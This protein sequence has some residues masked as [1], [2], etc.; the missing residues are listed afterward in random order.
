MTVR[1]ALSGAVIA[2]LLA[3]VVPMASAQTPVAHDR[4]H[5]RWAGAISRLHRDT[6]Y[7]A[8]GGTVVDALHYGLKLRWA[9]ATKTL[10][11]HETLTFRAA[12]SATRFSVELLN[13]LAV[14][15]A[16][17]NGTS[18]IPK[19]S[20]DHVT[21]AVP[22]QRGSRYVLRLTY[23]GVP[24]PVA[25]PTHRSDFSTL[26]FTPMPDGSAWTM[27]EPFGAY[28]WYAVNDTPAD[29]AYYDF[30]VT[31]P[32]GMVGVANGALKS[33]THVGS[34]TITRWHLGAPCASYLTTLAIGDYVH[35][36]LRGVKGLPIDLWT[37][38]GNRKEL[39]ILGYAPKAVHFLQHQVGRYPFSTLGIVAVPMA[40]AMET[41]T[42]VTM[43]NRGGVLNRDNV[44]HE[45]A[46]QWYGDTVTPR[47]WSDLWMNE[48]M[49]L[50]LAEI[51]WWA[52]SHHTSTSSLLANFDN[53][54]P[55]VRREF[56]APAAYDARDFGEINVYA[57]PA[58]MWDMLRQRV[59]TARFDT[60]IRE[61]PAT[62]RHAS[63]SRGG[64]IRWW[65]R[66]TD[67]DLTH[68]FRRW[69]LATKEPHWH[70]G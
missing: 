39:R 16:R 25:A 46:H 40:S 36:V 7:P 29:K 62:H 59:G 19:H 31:A 53:I 65:S 34:S 8:H 44:V 54:A 61:W 37:H 22:V 27:Q 18:T 70:A 35:H 30:T 3:A 26:G 56:G 11:G 5:D 20:N 6:T 64:L 57:I 52:H 38:R 4:A 9:P 63:S 1:L 60:L 23:A 50:Y 68:F 10:T 17:V 21:F 67:Q 24:H 13:S 33:R 49:A 43:G 45:I 41:Q 66:H 69:L 28:T 2:A 12:R 58:L 47:D 48:G 55:E 15:S 14:S 32:S 51:R 42:M